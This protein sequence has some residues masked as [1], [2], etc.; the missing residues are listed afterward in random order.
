MAT[1]LPF[2]LI[3]TRGVP[4]AFHFRVYDP[5]APAVTVASVKG[6]ADRPWCWPAQGK[7][8]PEAVAAGA[9]TRVRVSVEATT[10]AASSAFFMPLRLLG[11]G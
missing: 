10:V 8:Q 2:A 3:S 6:I 9:A 5:S 11:S 7:S 4:L 1:T